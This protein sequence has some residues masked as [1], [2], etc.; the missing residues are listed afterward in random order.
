MKKVVSIVPMLLL[1][2]SLSF[3]QYT[4]GQSFFEQYVTAQAMLKAAMQ[5]SD[6]E[7]IAMFL[8]QSNRATMNAMTIFKDVKQKLAPAEAKDLDLAL[9]FM[10]NWSNKD[11]FEEQDIFKIVLWFKLNENKQQKTLAKLI[12]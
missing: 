4:K 12:K 2:C 1:V 6:P 10:L 5:Y 7:K 9:D 11:Y 3:G 8:N